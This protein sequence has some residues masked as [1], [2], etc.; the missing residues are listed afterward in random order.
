MLRKVDFTPEPLSLMNIINEVFKSEGK[1]GF[2]HGSYVSARNGLVCSA[3]KERMYYEDG[4]YISSTFYLKNQ[5]PDVDIVLIASDP[6]KFK[7]LLNDYIFK[8]N[9]LQ[10][11]NYFLT[12]NVMSEEIFMNEVTSY[13]P[14]AIK[15]ILKYREILIFGEGSLLAVAKDEANKFITDIDKGVQDDYDSR[16]SLLKN[17]LK[18]GVKKFN[19]SRL[20]Y[21][22][23]FPNYFEQVMI[24]KK[25]GFPEKRE[26]IVFPRPMDLKEYIDKKNGIK[27]FLR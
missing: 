8:N 2:I 16:K 25:A 15:R 24:K 4:E 5:P 26:K 11:L 22:D 20:D 18:L 7:S 21:L 9:I 27:K 12:L 17:K 13:N 19:L 6:C 10:E 3:Y 1:F 14:T 23:K